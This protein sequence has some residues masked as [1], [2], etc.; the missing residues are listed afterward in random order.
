MLGQKRSEVG[1]AAAKLRNGLEKLDEG[2]T[3]VAEM[4]VTLEEKKVTVAKATQD[5]EELLVVIVQD[6]R[7]VSGLPCNVRREGG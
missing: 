2:A 6:R 7:V 1:D 5:C 3:Q 4:S